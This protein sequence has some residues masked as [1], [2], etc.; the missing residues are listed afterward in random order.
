MSEG[1][2]EAAI[3]KMQE[4]WGRLPSLEGEGDGL[5]GTNND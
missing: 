3:K 5:E 2:K 4:L 1:E